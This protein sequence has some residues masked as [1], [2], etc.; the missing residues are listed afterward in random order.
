MGQVSVSI[1]G[2]AYSI[3]C[4][5][6]QEKHLT[7]LAAYVDEQVTGLAA[8][9]GQVGD[10]RLMLMAS[11][12]LADELWDMRGRIKKLEEE[13]ATVRDAR[14]VALERTEEAEAAVAEILEKAAQRLDT[15]AQRI[16]AS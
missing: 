13:V 14:S 16:E 2:R 3:A 5:D 8:Q 11:L 12:L 4:D 1:N 15:M 7:E 10:A 9:V 6:G